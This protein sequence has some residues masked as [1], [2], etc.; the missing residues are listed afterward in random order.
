[1]KPSCR[2]IVVATPLHSPHTWPS[3]SRLPIPSKAR[4]RVGTRDCRPRTWTNAA[5]IIVRHRPGHMR[6]VSPT[7]TP[8]PSKRCAGDIPSARN[9]PSASDGWASHHDFT[10]QR[11]APDDDVG[12]ESSGCGSAFRRSRGMSGGGTRRP[13]RT[14]PTP[15]LTRAW[16]S[17]GARCNRSSYSSH[18]LRQKHKICSVK[19]RLF[20]PLSMGDRMLSPLTVEILRE[21]TRGATNFGRRH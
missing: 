21:A 3:S 13:R 17:A 2:Q 11:A 4:P 5:A 8:A 9:D 7:R 20:R 10:P 15:V 18:V 14:C 16:L 6:R 19:G 1:M 12:H